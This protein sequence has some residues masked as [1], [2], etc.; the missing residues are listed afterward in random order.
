MAKGMEEAFRVVLETE[1]I[2]G[3]EKLRKAL[4]EVGDASE[5]AAGQTEELFD[6]L[7]DL[8]KTDDAIG[9]FVKFKAALA[10]TDTRLAAARAGL[11]KLNQEFDRSD[12]SSVRV[13]R[14]FAQAEQQVE[15]LT[16]QQRAQTLEL[17]R[18]SGAL[19]KAG[20]DTLNLGAA[21]QDVGTRMGATVQKIAEVNRGL[22]SMGGAASKAT[23]DVQGVGKQFDVLQ[24]SLTKIAG[25]AAAVAGALKG[26]AMSG[27]AFGEAVKLEQQLAEVQSVA[28]GAA[29][30][31]GR[32]RDAAQEAAARTGMSMEAV[33]SGMAELARAGLD[34]EQTIAALAPT[35]DLAQGA[36][37]GLAQAVEIAT[38]TLTQFGLEATEAQRVADVLAQA[39]NS[40]QSS[41][42]GLGNSLGYVA[43]LANQLGMSLE[44]TTAVL[45][46]LADEGF[47]G[48]RAGTALRN[49]FSQLMDPGSK[50]REELEK[51]G[52][53]GNDF[54]QI[55]QQ[56]AARG[57]EGK[58]A[59]LSLDQTARPA[60]L[61][62]FN[63]GGDSIRKFTEDLKNAEGA[64]ARTA[65]TVRDTLGNAWARFKQTTENALS[66]LIDPLLKPLQVELEALA[67]RVDAFAKSPAFAEL[68]DELT[69]AFSEGLQAVRT[70][71]EQADFDQIARD[72]TNFFTVLGE[73]VREF[74]ETKDALATFGGLAGDLT[75]KITPL[76]QS[77]SLLRGS[78]EGLANVIRS[79]RDE[80]GGFVE[81]MGMSATGARD[82][83]ASLKAA[84]ERMLALRDGA[85]P[86]AKAIAEVGEAA[87]GAA[88]D[89]AAAAQ[90]T[91]AATATLREAAVKAFTELVVGAQASGEEIREAFD[92]ALDPELTKEQV[93]RLNA[94]LRVAFEAGVI[95]AEEMGDAVTAMTDKVTAAGATIE[96]LARRS[97]EV[98]TELQTAIKEGAAP[99]VIEG[100]QARFDML[101]QRIK[102]AERAAT[103]M[104]QAMGDAAGQ[105]MTL[106]GAFKQLRLAS[107]DSLNATRDQALLA[108]NTISAAAR[109]GKAATEDVARAFE[110]YARAA[111]EAAR[112]SSEAVQ[113]QVDDQL[114]L[115]GSAL[116]LS[117]VLER[118]GLLGKESGDQTAQAMQNAASAVQDVA[119]AADSAS[120]SLRN[121]AG[122]STSAASATTQMASAMGQ[123]RSEAIGASVEL[124]QT[125][126][127]F[128]EIIAG[129]ARAWERG[130]VEL[131]SA[132]YEQNEAL[133]RQVALLREQNMALDETGQRVLELR[134]KY[135]YL[136][137][138]RLRELAQEQLRAEQA[139]KQSEEQ[140]KALSSGNE[141]LRERNALLSQPPW[142][143]TQKREVDIRVSFEA[144]SARVVFDTSDVTDA[145]IRQLAQ[146]IIA[147]IERDM[148]G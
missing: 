78:L 141:L 45:S 130:P 54:G 20:V 2:E 145:Q 83:S 66:N 40:S 84:E 80:L 27:D 117:E 104:G 34:T 28:G 81:R 88:A 16:K 140:N 13:N 36:G 22:S 24:F 142:E 87:A 62:L 63:K 127:L 102:E 6:E 133:E 119:D 113:K 97:A 132:F 103:G 5:T 138:D 30:Q 112:Y 70:F 128:Q 147:V 43:P 125:S 51:L 116:G 69:R 124:S 18:A 14:A 19:S 114:R 50:F 38:T 122:S 139:A 60:I 98:W 44:D 32:L 31:M 65:A 109:E 99:E 86:A 61:A 144:K 106:E 111:R 12:T 100:L 71:A 48:E 146:R 79:N 35:L 15:R 57:E 67:A 131:F 56:L 46:A 55:L 93:A 39:A 53:T 123:V 9:A 47:R 41:V 126:A 91:A 77:I 59:L 76:A 23:A 11:E 105:A 10:D 101:T 108:F 129:R 118:L 75:G 107:Q 49:V 85:K 92:K 17:Q 42:Q 96:A 134:K 120:G 3:V 82:M 4:K 26:I 29:E 121:M 137:D 148:P 64:A 95:S 143:T 68:R 110:G 136:S 7:T 72:V 89:T 52:I 135:S 1:G 115:K 21:Q 58:R 33:T 74:N 73:S 25:L 37:V 90:Q 8:K 94:S